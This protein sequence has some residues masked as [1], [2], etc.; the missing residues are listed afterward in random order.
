[1]VNKRKANDLA[2]GFKI[3][4]EVFELLKERYGE[5]LK[6]N[7][8]YATFDFETDDTQLELKSRRIKS[9]TYPTMMLSYHKL[10]KAQDDLGKKKSIILFNLN[11]GLF[12]WEYDPN[13]FEISMGGTMKRGCDERHL[14]GYIPV[15]NLKRFV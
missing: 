10:K 13:G 12:E 1:M 14:C 2:F 3:E 6:Q 5:K 7:G 15:K 9:T 4:K 8:R 11:D